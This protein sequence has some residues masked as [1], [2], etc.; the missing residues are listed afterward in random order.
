MYGFCE[1]A[2]IA[3]VGSVKTGLLHLVYTSLY[4]MMAQNLGLSSVFSSSIRRPQQEVSNSQ[5]III[6]QLQGCSDSTL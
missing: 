3:R 5:C 1:G 2:E 4:C 6:Y